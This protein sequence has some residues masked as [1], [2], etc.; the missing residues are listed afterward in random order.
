MVVLLQA[1]EDG[2]KIQRLVHKEQGKGKNPVAGGAA[3]LEVSAGGGERGMQSLQAVG[4]GHPLPA[5]QNLTIHLSVAHR[6]RRERLGLSACQHLPVL[7][8]EDR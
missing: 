2:L 8:R 5:G 3:G 7:W 4:I 6:S 1:R